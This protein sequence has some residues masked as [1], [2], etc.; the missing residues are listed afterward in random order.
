[1]EM[2]LGEAHLLD[3]IVGGV[4]TM[5]RGIGTYVRRALDLGGS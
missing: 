4:E 3:Y 5:A 2:G 1:M